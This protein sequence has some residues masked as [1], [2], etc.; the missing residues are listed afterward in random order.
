M[1]DSPKNKNKEKKKGICKSKAKQQKVE[2]SKSCYTS[3][4]IIS[5]KLRFSHP[6]SKSAKMNGVIL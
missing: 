2:I 5:Y 4:R 6:M 1:Y 3:K